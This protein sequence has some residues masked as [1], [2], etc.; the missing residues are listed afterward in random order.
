MGEDPNK[1]QEQYEKECAE[2]TQESIAALSKE[3]LEVL[4]VMR[5]AIIE[6]KNKKTIGSDKN[7]KG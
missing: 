3:M 6:I 4:K 1:L 5:D 7:G 2:R